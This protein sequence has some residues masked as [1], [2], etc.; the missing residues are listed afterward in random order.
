MKTKLKLAGFIIVSSLSLS[1]QAA[2]VSVDPDSFATG[3]DISN[4]YPDVTLTTCFGEPD[5]C[6]NP[7]SV[8]AVASPDATTGNLV[9]GQ[10][11]TNTTWGNG[12]FEW[13]QV[14]FSVAVDSVSLD[15]ASNDAGGDSNAQLLAFNS[16]GVQIDIDSSAF[17]SAGNFVTLT[18]TGSDIAYVQAY[19][20]EFNRA[21]NGVL[22][23][24]IYNTVDVPEPASLALLGLGLAVIG[25]ARRK[26]LAA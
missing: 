16:L 6:N 15:F 25:L 13:L 22:D 23:N 24:L 19:W 1:A 5:Q 26:K 18:V 3:T 4:L 11:A 21:E 8:F 20:D 2:L 7:G 12:V 14:D 10:S 9:F 17:V